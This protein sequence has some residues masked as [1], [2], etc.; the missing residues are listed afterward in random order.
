MSVPYPEYA[1][2]ADK[3]RRRPEPCAPGVPVMDSEMRFDG[4][5]V[6]SGCRREMVLIEEVWVHA[7]G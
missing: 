1:D 6:C 5:I 3:F 7:G 2:P 4:E